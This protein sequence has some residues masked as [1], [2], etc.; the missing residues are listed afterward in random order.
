MSK[1]TLLSFTKPEKIRTELYSNP[2]TPPQNRNLVTALVG[3]VNM[4]NGKPPDGLTVNVPFTPIFRKLG[5]M[6]EKGLS[7]DRYNWF[8]KG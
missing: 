5:K 6:P 3:L 4:R 8:I 2:S 1:N 7:I